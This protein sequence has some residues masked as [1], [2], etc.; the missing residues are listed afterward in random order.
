M[1]P[2]ASA[3]TVACASAS[4][5]SAS[6][7]FQGLRRFKDKFQP[8]WEPRYMAALIADL[9]GIGVPNGNIHTET[10]GSE[11]SITP[12]IAATPARQPHAPAGVQG[13]GPTVSFSRSGLALPWSDSY[14]SL[15]DFAE[16]CDVPVRWSCRTGVCHTCETALIAGRVRYDPEPIDAPASGNVL[17]C[18]ARPEGDIE[19][20]L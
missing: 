14:A 17:I 12:G 15:L 6:T 20:D 2:S 3:N 11:A 13:H 10:F 8:D 5:G 18:C 19:L 9:N 1:A 16:A 4:A 7:C